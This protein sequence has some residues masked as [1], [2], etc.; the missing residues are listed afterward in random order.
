VAGAAD[1]IFF[2]RTFPGSGPPYFEVVAGEDGRVTYRESPDEQDPLTFS[3][4]HQ[5]RDWLFAKARELDNFNRKLESKRRIAF[6]GDKV[7]RFESDGAPK[8]EARF[9]HTE[10]E[11]AAEIVVWFLRV[12]ETERYFIDLERAVQFDR[13]GVNDALLNL[14]AAY[15]KGRVV[16]PEQFLPMLEKIVADQKIMHVARA[17]ASALI[18]GIT[19]PPSE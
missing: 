5:T 7:L 16:A 2:S 12:S 3:L 4:S 13:L 18:E 1:S 15:E 17:R 19:A 6:T 11:A 9:A 14:H 8:G 10:D